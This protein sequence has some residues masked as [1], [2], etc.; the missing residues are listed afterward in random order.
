MKGQGKLS[1]SFG[2]EI[3]MEGW[4][5]LHANTN[6]TRH[7]LEDASSFLPFPFLQ[8][9]KCLTLE[10]VQVLFQATSTTNFLNDVPQLL[11]CLIAGLYSLNP[12]SSMGSTLNQNY[13]QHTRSSLPTPI[14]LWH[15]QPHF[16]PTGLPS[17]AS[18]ISAFLSSP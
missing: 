13:S 16:L 14:S 6:F 17:S 9:R 4:T 18:S 7:S 15:Q 3:H 11:G 10:Q 5:D 2:H 12:S 8:A 1:N